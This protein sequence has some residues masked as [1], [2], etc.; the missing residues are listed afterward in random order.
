MITI[1]DIKFK[2]FFRKDVDENEFERMPA[3]MSIV[4]CDVIEI[5]GLKVMK[6]YKEGSR[7]RFL[8]Y[9]ASKSLGH[10]KWFDYSW[11]E[12]E[13]WKQ[14]TEKALR[15]FDEEHTAFLL[16]QTRKE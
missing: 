6:A 13:L 16:K 15:E 4:V 12:P 5:K 10:N 2:F 8:I 7:S 11:V 1:D 9:P 14:I 3:S